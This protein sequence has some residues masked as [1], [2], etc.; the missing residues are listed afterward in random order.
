[1]NYENN[2]FNV[3]QIYFKINIDHHSYLIYISV[4]VSSVIMCILLSFNFFIICLNIKLLEF[5][6]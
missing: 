2:I 4:N 6:T 1:M 5:T 3:Q